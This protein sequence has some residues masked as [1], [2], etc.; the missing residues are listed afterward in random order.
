MTD[1]LEMVSVL[2]MSQLLYDAGLSEHFHPKERI[3]DKW[4]DFRHK[5]ATYLVEHGCV[6]SYKAKLSENPALKTES[7][8]QEMA[9][10]ID[11]SQKPPLGIKPEIY[12]KEQR[13]RDLA[14]AIDRYIQEGFFGGEWSVQ[15][16]LWCDE[17]SRRL[18]E[19]KISTKD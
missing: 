14:A 7:L 10:E 16:Q 5:I 3:T 13:L 8:L 18:K 17:L 19:F 9:K 15:V 2:D 1:I 6:L 4:D 11:K 12:Y